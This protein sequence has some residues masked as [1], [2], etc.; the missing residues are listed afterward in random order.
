MSLVHVLTHLTWDYHRIIII[1]RALI[2]TFDKGGDAKGWPKCIRRK[3]G[4][5]RSTKGKQVFHGF[6][7]FRGWKGWRY[8]SGNEPKTTVNFL[9]LQFY[10]TATCFSVRRQRKYL[11]CTCCFRSKCPCAALWQSTLTGKEIA[12]YFQERSGTEHL[13][14][15]PW[16]K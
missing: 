10:S 14:A 15:F 4:P 2:A 11:M 13:A 8:E 3:D 9:D 12:S 6:L 16:D 1:T 7:L 5:G